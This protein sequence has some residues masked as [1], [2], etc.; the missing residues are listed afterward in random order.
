MGSLALNVDN[1]GY[2][3]LLYGVGILAMAFSVTAFQFK[4]RVTIVLCSFL[5]QTCWVLYFILQSDFTSGI[6]CGLNAIMFAIFAKKDKW[7]WATSTWCVVLFEVIVCAFSLITFASWR[8]IFP[9]LA[10][11]FGVIANS[12]STEKRLRQF[13]LLWC[14]FWLINSALKVYP[15]AFVNDLLCTGSAFLSLIRYRNKRT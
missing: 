13:S 7:K 15:V 6:A 12:R 8:D 1:L 2:Y 5:G 14:S 11:F 9:L 4:H 10:G 3:I